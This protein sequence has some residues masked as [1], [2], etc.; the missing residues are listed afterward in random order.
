MQETITETDVLDFLDKLRLFAPNLGDYE[1]YS[2]NEHFQYLIK[3]TNHS[4][5]IPM[6]QLITNRQKKLT[7]EDFK[8]IADGL[9]KKEAPK[10]KPPTP[11]SQVVY[12]K[13]VDAGYKIFRI[14]LI[15]FLIGAALVAGF[16]AL[17]KFGSK[18]NHDY[19]ENS[20]EL[21]EDPEITRPEDYLNVEG[22]WRFNWLREIK[23]EGTIFNNAEKTSYK[24]IVIKVQGKSKT[25]T[26]IEERNYTIYEQIPPNSSVTFKLH[27]S[28][29]WDNDVESISI[30]A[31]R[32]VVE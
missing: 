12:E 6:E 3:T 8:T 24:D 25:G 23:L 13:R 5:K 15:L 30:A 9:V 7:Q 2:S 27:T 17:R 29:S 11:N 28:E 26:V 10:Q 16:F 22:N 18:N 19:N 31:A 32:A 1:Y 4:L 20:N 14:L 21:F